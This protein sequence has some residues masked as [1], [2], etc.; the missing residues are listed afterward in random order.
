MR[1]GVITYYKVSNFGANL[2]AISTYCYLKKNGH[3]PVFINFMTE[4]MYQSLEN[5]KNSDA[6]VGHIDTIDG[7]IKEQTDVCFSAEDIMREVANHKIEAIIIGSDAL[8]QHHPWI[9]RLRKGRR[10]PIYVMP[11]DKS[12][13]YPN[14]FWGVDLADK[15]PAALLSVSSQNSPYN[16][17]SSRLKHKM[18]ESL[19]LFRY[20]S[21]RDTWTRDM[22]KSILHK[23][24]PITPDP[25]FGFNA[26]AGELIPSKEELID[27]F[28]LPS[29]YLLFGLFD[30]NVDYETLVELKQLLSKQGCSCV[31]IYT[32]TGR[33]FKHPFDYEI[34][35]PFTPL[36]WY[37]LL[38]NAYAY[39]GC[40]M[41]PIVV[42]LHNAVPCFSIDNWG[43]TDFWGRK[44]DDGSSKVQ[45]IMEVFGVSQN[46]RLIQQ[47]I[48]DITA[49]EILEALVSFPKENVKYKSQEYFEQYKILMH[50]LIE[51]L[52]K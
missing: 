20:I 23:E 26:N 39:V 13:L 3:E 11:V 30:Q 28:K 44:K 21:V 9:S 34:Y 2:Q 12:R 19:S 40:N 1:I 16:L 5:N 42:C 36:E 29:K 18:A 8:L 6:W 51:S 15:I 45:H 52:K 43:K 17:F 46:H 33:G 47:N 35:A 7:I 24:V 22:V 50:N 48:C 31:S 10:K 27:K 32:P 41:H 37:G 4:Q 14:P 38:K 49:K 25:V